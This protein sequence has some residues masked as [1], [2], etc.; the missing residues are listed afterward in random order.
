MSDLR[1]LV[2][3]DSAMNRRLLREFLARAGARVTLAETGGE[4]ER[5]ARAERPDVIVLDVVLPDADG[6]ELC[7]RWRTEAELRDIP[8]LLV[9]GERLEDEDRAAGLRSGAMGYLV[10]PFA[11][12]ELIAQVHLLDELG[13][14]HQEL[15]ARAAE[16]E[17]SNREL[18]QF[19]YVVSH[20]LQEPLRT[21]AGYGRMLAEQLGRSPGAGTTRLL[22]TLLDGV[23]R[24]QRLIDD[25]LAYSRAGRMALE[26]RPVDLGGVVEEVLASL[27]AAV[28]ESGAAIEVGPL[29]TLPG[30]RTL[31]VQLF[32]NLLSNAIKFR[33]AAPQAVRMFSEQCGNR[34][35]VT[36]ADSGIGIAPQYCQ[37]IFSVFERLHPRDEY[38]GTG[39]GLAICR[40]IAE[41]HGGRI[42][43]ESE[44]DRGSAFHIELP[45]AADAGSGSDGV[46]GSWSD[47]VLE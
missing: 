19:A 46:L 6:I 41:R 23:R 17:A 31:L 16:L 36:V 5:L 47:E 33:G 15:K 32:Q 12:A 7:R 42:W 9:S 24:M 18:Q 37:R 13:R 25:L 10:K 43:V 26:S 11:E 4:G 45:A 30:N 21:V 38:P 14:T 34:W 35:R 29:P 2:I 3:D 40:R 8:V 39:V 28:A 20:D 27:Q 1:V 22:Q 44:P